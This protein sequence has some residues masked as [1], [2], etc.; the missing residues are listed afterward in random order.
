MLCWEIVVEERANMGDTT[1]LVVM[2]LVTMLMCLPMPHAHAQGEL[3]DPEPVPKPAFS[4][5]SG[6]SVPLRPHYEL[7]EPLYRRR[8]EPG[9]L[10]TASQVVNLITNNND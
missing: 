1:Q 4:S 9:L 7:A 6:G 3:A 8:N 10:W 5:V 2:A